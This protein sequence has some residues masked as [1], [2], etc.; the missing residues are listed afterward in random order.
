MSTP[1]YP[2]SIIARL[3]D[4]TERR[5]RQLSDEAVIPKPK[6]GKYDL[7]GS[8]MGYIRYLK[9]IASKKQPADTE[10][11]QVRMRILRAQAATAEMDL[12]KETG[13]FMPV[14]KAISD[15]KNMILAFKS[16]MLALPYRI[17]CS[18]IHLTELH[19]AEKVTKK[20]VYEA[21]DELAE[22]DPR[23]T[24]QDIEG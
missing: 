18:V 22:Y 24:K 7:A 6:D 15:W 14:D 1:S 20:L 23:K 17:A 5:V 8:I 2:A 4:L 12:K 16:R 3:F 10:E 9:K 13:E 19:E 11:Q 21:L